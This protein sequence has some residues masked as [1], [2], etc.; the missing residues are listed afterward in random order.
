[1]QCLSLHAS[2]KHALPAVPLALPLFPHRLL[3]LRPPIA[4]L[5]IPRLPFTLP[6]T[7]RPPLSPSLSPNL[8]PSLSPPLPVRP[9]RVLEGPPLTLH[10]APPL[11]Y[12]RSGALPPVAAV[13]QAKAARLLPAPGT[14]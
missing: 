13:R 14:S 1:M 11:P 2:R 7:V 10:H 12:H 5:L 6:P 9:L 8:S 4:T 3:L